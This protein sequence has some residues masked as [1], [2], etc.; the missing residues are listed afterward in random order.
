MALG[1]S[2]LERS[3]VPLLPGKYYVDG[4]FVISFLNQSFYLLACLLACLL[5]IEITGK[6]AVTNEAVLT[7]TA[8]RS[9][10]SRQESFRTAVR[11]RDNKCV[12]TEQGRVRRSTWSGLKAALI[13]PLAYHDYWVQHN[14]AR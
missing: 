9:I 11:E 12:T 4:M 10:G 13:F 14:L 7:H 5:A 8:S 6:F 2:T 3:D 1:G